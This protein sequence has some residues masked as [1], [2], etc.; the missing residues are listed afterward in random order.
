MQIKKQLNKFKLFMMRKQL[1]KMEFITKCNVV[2]S[3]HMS[4]DK[5]LIE[6]G[7]F[8]EVVEMNG[9]KKISIDN[10]F[11]KFFAVWADEGK[12]LYYKEFK[13]RKSIH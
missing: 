1:K 2:I 9:E 13:T 5:T 10:K 3:E 8:L 4:F 12:T 6:L 11:G 7:E